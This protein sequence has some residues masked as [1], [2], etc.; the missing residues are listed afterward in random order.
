[1]I[2]VSTDLVLEISD[3]AVCLISRD[4]YGDHDP[5]CA[6]M[7]VINRDELAALIEALKLQYEAGCSA[8]NAHLR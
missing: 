2:Q 6:G 5:D 7:V 1:M 4:M 3:G 8:D